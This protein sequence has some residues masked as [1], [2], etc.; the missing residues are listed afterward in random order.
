M[1]FNILTWYFGIKVVESPLT[2]PV[3]DINIFGRGKLKMKFQK[4][5]S[6]FDQMTRLPNKG[7]LTAK[8]I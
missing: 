1:I 7:R 4:D 5:V 8:R 2:P 3:L 6:I